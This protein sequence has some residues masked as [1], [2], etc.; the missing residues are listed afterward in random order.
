MKSIIILSGLGALTLFSEIINFKKWLYPIILLG[1]LACIGFAIKDW[2]APA[3]H[4]YNN[5]MVFDNMAIAFTILL[6]SIVFIWLILAKDFLSNE[7]HLTDHLS[8]ILFASVGAMMMVSYGNL[9]MLFLGIETLSIPLYIMAGS[10]KNSLNSNESALKYFLM[11]AFA[12]GFLLYG[13]ALIYGVTGAFHLHTI[14]DYVVAERGNYP[15]MFYTGIL[16]ILIGIS[17]KVSAFPFQFWAPDVYTGA[18]TMVTA[19]MS[20]I[21]KTAAFAAFYRLFNTCFAG[22]GDVWIKMVI[23]MSVAT[24]LIGNIGAIIQTNLKRMLAYSAIAHAG[25]LLIGIASIDLTSGNDSSSGNTIFYYTLAYSIGS[26][27]SFGILYNVAN[28]T[29]SDSIEAFNGLGKRNPF[30]AFAMTISLL[31][32][33]G[34][35]P[36]AGFFG[37]YYLFLS[38]IHQGK[39][40]LVMF[41]VL[42]SL[43]GIYYYLKVIIAMYFKPKENLPIVVVKDY[44]K[45]TIAFL[46]IILIVLGLAPELFIKLF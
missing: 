32:L 10:K 31:S 12:T 13:I 24:L 11:G 38:A 30:L 25:Y 29:E 20:T 21:V 4:F 16:F 35:P 2:G 28:S 7:T 6:C 44:H 3:H 37:K 22:V 46:L 8:L 27:I 14:A 1:L 34:I 45:I 36:M 40:W 18:P 9:V 43:I 42:A 41:A 17:F 23:F 15:M 39:I 5:M 33:A 19:F 26:L